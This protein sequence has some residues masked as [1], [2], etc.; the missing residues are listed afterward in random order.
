MAPPRHKRIRDMYIQLTRKE[1]G[2]SK[3][4]QQATSLSHV[5]PPH[6]ASLDNPLTKN[7]HEQTFQGG[8]PARWVFVW[9][10]QIASHSPRLKAVSV[11]GQPSVVA[12]AVF[13]FVGWPRFP[14]SNFMSRSRWRIRG[15]TTEKIN[16]HDTTC[17]PLLTWCT[18]NFNINFPHIGLL[19]CREEEVRGRTYPRQIS[20]PCPRDLR[21]GW[22]IRHTRH[23]QEKIPRSGRFDCW[24]IPLCNPEAHPTRAGEGTVLVLLEYYSPKW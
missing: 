18:T 10:W 7:K 11:L 13:A 15:L 21:E 19:F 20:W 23:W 4:W 14:T 22:S 2:T 3:V 12:S 24:P 5:A 16:W 1:A 9:F 8:A 6:Q 17:E